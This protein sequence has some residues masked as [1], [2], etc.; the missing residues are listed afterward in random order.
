MTVDTDN[1]NQATQTFSPVPKTSCEQETQTTTS[2]VKDLY[3]I[4]QDNCRICWEGQLDSR[5]IWVGCLSKD[6]CNHRVHAKCI[7]ICVK[8]RHL[9]ARSDTTV[10][11]IL[12]LLFKYNLFFNCIFLIYLN[13]PFPIRFFFSFLHNSTFSL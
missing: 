6:N 7:G 10:L 12:L 9:L 2:Y 8:P 1:T 11:G 5:A 3:D 13:L 4:N